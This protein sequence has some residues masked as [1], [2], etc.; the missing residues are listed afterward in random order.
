ML[1]A[2]PGKGRFVILGK[3]VHAITGGHIAKPR[4]PERQRI[5]DRFAQDDFLRSLQRFLIPHAP[6]RTWQVQMQGRSFAQVRRD[7]AAIHAE[8]ISF[9]IEDRKHHRAIEVLMARLA[10]NT[11]PLQTAAHLVPGLAVLI[12][13]RQPQLAVGEADLEVLHH[14]GMIQ[15]A[16]LQIPQRFRRLLQRLV[17]KRDHIAQRLLVVGIRRHRRGQF[18]RRAFANDTPIAGG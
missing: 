10:Q 5:D 18:H 15:A 14:L 6:M 9:E 7:L 2:M 1:H 4:A 16:A 3:P 11:Q 17:I 8:N 12:R 13:Q